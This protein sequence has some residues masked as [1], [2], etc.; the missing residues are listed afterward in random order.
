MVVGWNPNNALTCIV[1][2]VS[3]YTVVLLRGETTVG[4]LSIVFSEF[5]GV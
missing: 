2:D 1:S 4:K 5:C 3:C